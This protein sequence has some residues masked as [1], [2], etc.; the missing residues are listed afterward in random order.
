MNILTV[1]NVKE[2]SEIIFLWKS[3]QILVKLMKIKW[4]S[5]GL[6]SLKNSHKQFGHAFRPPFWA[7]P[8]FTQFFLGRASLSNQNV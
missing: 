6:Y 2:D 1:T 3:R 7:M 5:N 4:L 8:K